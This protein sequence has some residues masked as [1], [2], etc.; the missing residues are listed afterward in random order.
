M[1]ND[2]ARMKDQYER[3]LTLHHNQLGSHQEMHNYHYEGKSAGADEMSSLRTSLRL[4]GLLS[5][6]I[7]LVGIYASW[8]TYRR[9]KKQDRWTL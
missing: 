8:L 9:H 5:V 2:F 6:F 1:E 3:K 4:W 7:V